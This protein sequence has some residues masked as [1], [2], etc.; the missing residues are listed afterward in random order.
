VTTFKPPWDFFPLH[1]TVIPPFKV[2]LEVGFDQGDLMTFCVCHFDENGVMSSFGGHSENWRETLI[3]YLDYIE[4]AKWLAFVEPDTGEPRYIRL[5]REYAAWHW[6]W[7]PGRG[8]VWTNNPPIEMGDG[9][10]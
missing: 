5:N 1:E 10:G 9:H 6:E 4:M 3:D 7:V 8:R 2:A